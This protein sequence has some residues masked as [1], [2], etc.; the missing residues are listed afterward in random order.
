MK[1]SPWRDRTF[2]EAINLSSVSKKFC[3]ARNHILK[4]RAL[5]Y[6]RIYKKREIKDTEHQA[7]HRFWNLTRKV[8]AMRSLRQPKTQAKQSTL[9]CNQLPNRE[10]AT[11]TSTTTKTFSYPPKI[12]NSL[13]RS[14][15]KNE[16]RSDPLLFFPKEKKNSLK[17]NWT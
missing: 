17:F 13:E 2:K 16:S 11:W 9:E 12:S 15:K 8:A 14:S 3:L 1:A 4:W 10:S 6:S 5:S 7:P